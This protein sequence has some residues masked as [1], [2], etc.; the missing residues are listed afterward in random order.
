MGCCNECHRNG[1]PFNEIV[2]VIELRSFMRIILAIFFLVQALF[3][4][5]LHDWRVISYMNDVRDVE[6]YLGA[7]WVS[8]SGGVYRFEPSDSSHIKYT[9]IDGLACLDLTSLVQDN[10]GNLLAGSKDGIICLYHARDETWDAFYDIRGQEIVDLFIYDDTLWVATNEGVGVFLSS[11]EKLE[12]RD[13]YNNLPFDP[14]RAYKVSVFNKRIFYATQNGIM[15][16][17]SDFIRYNLKI[18]DA[19]RTLTTENGLPSNSVSDLTLVAESLYIAT[20]GGVVWLDQDFTPNAVEGWT[21]GSVDRIISSENT[22]YFIRGNSYYRKNNDDWDYINTVGNVI[23]SGVLDNENTLWL[24]LAKD[25]L[26]KDGW[27][28]SYKVDGPGSNHVGVLIKDRQGTLWM[29]SGKLKLYFSDGFYKYDFKK[30]TNYR[31][32]DNLWD[33]KNST[34]YV[35]EDRFGNIWFG[36]WG[37]AITVISNDNMIFYHSWP[38]SGR[39][40]VS[41]VSDEQEIILQELTDDARNCLSPAQVSSDYYTVITHFNEDIDGNL[42]CSNYLAKEPKYI[43]VIP[44]PDVSENPSCS[45]WKYFGDRWSLNTEEST[46]TA[47]EFDAW[48]RLWMGTFQRGILVLDYNGTINDETDDQLFRINMSSDNLFSNTIVCVKRDLD[49]ILW[50]GTAGGLNSYQ[51]DPYGTNQIFYKH[52]GELG[53]IENKINQIF[54]DKYNNKWFATD[55]GLSILKGN[56]SPWDA[57]AWVHYT[58]ENSGLPSPIVNSV[59]VDQNSGEAYL[60][61]ESG[62]A[63]FSGPY[64]EYKED[65][66]QLIGGPNPF[67]IE[68]NSNYVIKNLINNASVKIMNIN[69]RLIR[70]L[71]QENGMIQGSRATWDGRDDTNTIVPSG[72]YIYIVYNEEGITGSGK[73]AVIRP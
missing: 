39:L 21:R 20:A 16:A 31:F 3:A 24:G 27:S 63:I 62:L 57:T 13:F 10:Y 61:T 29:A 59:F 46:I 32:Y 42:W 60:G 65:L 1:G 54:V 36:A 11:E 28:K 12:F 43:T 25:G 41:T 5:G 4:Q 71:T 8:S 67:V 34:D 44:N 17:S 47:L 18:I 66:T 35:Y 2:V 68:E 55:G 7:I 40:L 58:P 53:P 51:A 45:E 19:W 9:N 38:G 69:G 26:Q 50:I 72:V 73:I 56:K 52:V 64:S 30:W 14:G 70:K 23:T 6:F 37:G 49:G 33:R 48:G 15:H 22:M